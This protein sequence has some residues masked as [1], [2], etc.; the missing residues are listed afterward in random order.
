MNNKTFGI[1]HAEMDR[2]EFL[3]HIG[4]GMLMLTGAGMIFKSLT[5]TSREDGG[6][7]SV[8]G[9]YGMSAYGG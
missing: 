1:L 3:R 5:M 6:K 4:L 2:R 7:K 8:G 9:G